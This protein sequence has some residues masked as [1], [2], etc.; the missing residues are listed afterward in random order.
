MLCFEPCLT[1][2][3]KRAA[4][5]AY[6]DIMITAEYL[7]DRSLILYSV[8][9]HGGGEGL[10]IAVSFE[11]RGGNEEYLLT[12]SGMGLMYGEKRR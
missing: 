4:H 9:D 5:P 2:T 1:P 7:S 12:R 11:C 6:C 10:C 3:S 8:K